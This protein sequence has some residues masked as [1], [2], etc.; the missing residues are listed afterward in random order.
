VNLLT[1]FQQKPSGWRHR[2][3][4]AR[5]DVATELV[6]RRVFITPQIW[7]RQLYLGT[8]DGPLQHSQVVAITMPVSANRWRQWHGSGALWTVRVAATA[9]W[10]DTAFTNHV[11]VCAT[12]E[13]R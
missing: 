3:K 7:T 2:S 10:H 4:G 11:T 6:V 13:R 1:I 12:L 5:L 8:A 9:G